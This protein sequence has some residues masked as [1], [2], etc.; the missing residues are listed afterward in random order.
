VQIARVRELQAVICKLI[1][2]LPAFC[3]HNEAGV[4]ASLGEL[5]SLLRQLTA[6]TELPAKEEARRSERLP[7]K[8]G[9]C[10]MP[11]FGI[12]LILRRS[13]SLKRKQ[14]GLEVAEQFD[15]SSGRVFRLRRGRTIF[16]GLTYD[17]W[18]VRGDGNDAFLCVGRSKRVVHPG[19]CGILH[20]GVHLWLPPRR[21]ALWARGRCLVRRGGTT[22]VECDSEPLGCHRHKKP[23]ICPGVC[24]PLEQGLRQ[25][26]LTVRRQLTPL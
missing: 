3:T 9:P 1:L 21:V 7:S 11:G 14:V 13:R 25:D 4:A 26:N 8:L 23:S 15:H 19:L 6:K 22:M 10:G 20:S 24:V 17:L 12:L 2:R 5:C 16:G 18:S